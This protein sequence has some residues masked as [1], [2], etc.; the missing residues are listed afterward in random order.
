[1]ISQSDG[2]SIAGQSVNSGLGILGTVIPGPESVLNRMMKMDKLFIPYGAKPPVQIDQ[3]LTQGSLMIGAPQI[4]NQCSSI[5]NFR[6]IYGRTPLHLAAALSNRSSLE[7]LLFLGANPNMQDIYGQKPIAMASDESIRE[8]LQLKMTRSKELPC[9]FNIDTVKGSQKPPKVDGAPIERTQIVDKE[10]APKEI[11]VKQTGNSL[12]KQ[13]SVVSLGAGV[14]DNL[15]QYGGSNISKVVTGSNKITKGNNASQI[16]LDV[17]DL[18]NMMPEKIVLTRIGMENDN[19]LQY[20]IKSKAF[21]AC[22]YLITL[23]GVVFSPCY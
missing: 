12:L 1:M 20:A 9:H 19:Y 5:V 7:T 8:L 11:Q 10:V 2:N 14:G 4:S 16:S 23:P 3:A 17:K 22:V 13:N 6:D 15:S 18:N 21:Q